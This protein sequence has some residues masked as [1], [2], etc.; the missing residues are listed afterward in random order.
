MTSK[1]QR[2]Q[3][4]KKAWAIATPPKTDSVKVRLNTTAGKAV[5]SSE[6]H[7]LLVNAAGVSDLQ[8]ISKYIRRADVVEFATLLDSEQIEPPD[9]ATLPSSWTWDMRCLESFPPAM[10]FALSAAKGV[11]PHLRARAMSNALKA[12]AIAALEVDLDEIY[13]TD[14]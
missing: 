12:F 14:E 7:R 13:G 10:V 3:R 11:E 1:K 9:D 5:K 6:L 8:K 2:R 4:A